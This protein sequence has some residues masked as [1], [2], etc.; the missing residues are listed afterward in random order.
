MAFISLGLR[1]LVYAMAKFLP[2]EIFHSGL[3]GGGGGGGKSPWRS[4]A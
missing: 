1:L 4:L 3:V 2:R